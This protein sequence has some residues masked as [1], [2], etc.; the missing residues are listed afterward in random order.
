MCFIA[1]SVYTAGALE[2]GYFIH[3]QDIMKEMYDVDV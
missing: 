2:T 1:H 3:C